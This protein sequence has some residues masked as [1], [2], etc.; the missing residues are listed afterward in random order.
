PGGGEGG[1]GDGTS[2]S[3]GSNAG[4]YNDGSMPNSSWDS[5][6]GKDNPLN[7]IY[8]LYPYGPGNGGY[9]GMPYP[10]G[11]G[12][13]GIFSPYGPGYN[14]IN[15]NLTD[16]NKAATTNGS[17]KTKLRER[18]TIWDE[19][20]DGTSILDTQLGVVSAFED[21]LKD[22]SESN[23]LSFTS[24]L[25]KAPLSIANTIWDND[26]L[27]VT[28]DALGFTIDGITGSVG[29]INKFKETHS[30]ANGA[31]VFSKMGTMGK[32]G[33]K[34]LG[35]LGKNFGQRIGDSWKSFNSAKGFLGKTKNIASGAGDFF[36]KVKDFG[37]T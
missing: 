20:E 21:V 25:I 5:I 9:N 7:G 11:T 33:F 23:A 28:N 19:I 29:W 35:S 27:D 2:N 26:A 13:L 16:L 30:F 14:G 3:G 22:A 32:E 37:G 15:N 8:P 17:S 4:G 31:S 36:G 34:H 18:E 1:S 10:S 24:S 6:N 12:A